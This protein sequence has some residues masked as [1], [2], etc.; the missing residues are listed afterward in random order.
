MESEVITL[1]DIYTFKIEQ[2][3]ADRTVVGQLEATKLRPA[4]IHK[5][6]K[7]GVE[8]PGYL[9]AGNNSETPVAAPSAFVAPGMAQQ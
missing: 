7:R 8:L 5:F 6:E 2:V 4:F 9:F 3:L 1:Q